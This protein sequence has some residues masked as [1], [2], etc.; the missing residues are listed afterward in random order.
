[1]SSAKVMFCAW[2]AAWCCVGFCQVSEV[3]PLNWKASTIIEQDKSPVRL[4]LPHNSSDAIRQELLDTNT[5]RMLAKGARL[6]ESDLA[7][8]Q[9]APWPETGWVAL[10]QTGK[11]DKAYAA[12]EKRLK[13]Y[14]A[15]REEGHTRG[16]LLAAASAPLDLGRVSD[17]ALHF[18]VSNQVFFSFSAIKRMASGTYTNIIRT[19]LAPA[20]KASVR[21]AKT[22]GSPAEAARARA[23]K[24]KEPEK[25][26]LKLEVCRWTTFAVT[27][28]DMTWRYLVRLKKD[29]GLEDI[30]LERCD[31]KDYAEEYQDDMDEVEEETQEELRKTGIS[32]GTGAM[33]L[34]W[35]LKQEKLKARGI[36]WHT[37]GEL[38]PDK[39]YD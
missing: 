3:V 26:V 23:K 28:G 25:E 35:Q 34:F 37:P 20:R 17:P 33:R 29:K 16:F 38:N 10:F 1:M 24:E 13:G 12:L 8:V 19:N 21:P 14:V 11:P 2:L 4:Q 9:V 22:K 36:E 7:T 15:A 27:D 39:S 18:L 6:T 30:Q 31:S 5:L 32:G